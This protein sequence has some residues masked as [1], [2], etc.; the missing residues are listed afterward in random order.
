MVIKKKSC[1]ISHD[2][3]F[4]LMGVT[5]VCKISRGKALFCPKYPRVN[6]IIS[7]SLCLD[8]LYIVSLDIGKFFIKTLF[9]KN[10]FLIYILH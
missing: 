8:Y 4:F 1:V 9:F 7:S 10:D 5:Q 6:K 2:L 3:G